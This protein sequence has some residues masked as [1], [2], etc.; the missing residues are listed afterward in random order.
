MVRHQPKHDPESCGFCLSGKWVFDPPKYGRRFWR[1]LFRGPVCL[2]WEGGD[3]R[4]E[5]LV[6]RLTKEQLNG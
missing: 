6:T 5:R 4:N 1:H 2:C 3:W